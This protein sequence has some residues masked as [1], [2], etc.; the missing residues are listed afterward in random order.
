ML[1]ELLVVCYKELEGAVNTGG[2]LERHD[3]RRYLDLIT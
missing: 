3:A 1:K 2:A